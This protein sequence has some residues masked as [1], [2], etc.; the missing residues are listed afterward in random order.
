VLDNMEHLLPDA[1]RFLHDLHQRL[2]TL[3]LL[4]TSRLRLHLV[5]EQEFI[6]AP[7]PVPSS[8]GNALESIASTD[9][10]IGSEFPDLMVYPGVQLFVRRTQSRRAEFQITERNA[11]TVGA[12]CSVL[13]GIPLAIELAAAWTHLLTPAQLLMRLEHRFDLLKTYREDSLPERHRSLWLTLEISYRLL[14]PGLQRFFARLSI[15]RGGWTLEAAETV[16]VEARSLEYIAQLHDASL[17]VV[18]ETGEEMR[19][20]FLETVRDYAAEQLTAQER[21]ALARRHADF[22]LA[23]AEAAYPNRNTG[24]ESRWLSRLEADHGNLREAMTCLLQSEKDGDL[25]LRLAGMLSVFWE[26]R[27][28]LREG[29]HW[30]FQ[31]LECQSAP[32]PNRVM[33]LNALGYLHLRQ[34]D[35]PQ[36]NPLLEEALALARQLDDQE[37]CNFALERLGSAALYM[38]NYVLAE[39]YFTEALAGFRKVGFCAGEIAVLISLGVSAKNQGRHK[40]AAELFDNAL[41]LITQ[42]GNLVFEGI[43]LHNL[44]NV[45]RELGRFE[46]AKQFYL[47]SLDIHRRQD[48]RYWQ[49]VNLFELGMTAQQEGE[50]ETARTYLQQSITLCREV[51]EEFITSCCLEQ[52]GILA[53][54]ENNFAAAHLRL[55]E[56]LSLRQK[57]GAKREIAFT[58]EHL[59]RLLVSQQ[60]RE[61]AGQ[62]LGAAMQLR[63]DTGC[64]I[65]PNEQNAY[66]ELTAQIRSA[67][68]ETAFAEA[69]EA[70]RT[71]TPEEYVSEYV[72]GKF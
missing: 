23:F 13:E 62:L 53:Y 25:G 43:T 61:R 63:A 24:E 68:G 32:S 11:A 49:G 21:D 30:L 45:M 72:S 66:K 28:Y 37:G 54:Q 4:V 55:T 14:S 15:F 29:K 35:Y 64:P 16:C 7:L 20:R 67:L 42:T 58:L 34:G 31:A 57:L 9:G 69:L 10:M 41:A 39:K 51:G 52:M 50:R 19:Y 65:P 44:G 22:F 12:V 40:E 70:G 8:Q 33:A 47:R 26:R 46:Q 3:T 17:L 48:K 2:P 36:A 27:G 60:Q 1:V 18:E 38:S 59:A 71:L 6:V 56:S 5:G